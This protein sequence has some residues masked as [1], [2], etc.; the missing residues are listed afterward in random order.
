VV[1]ENGVISEQGRYD[2]LSRTEG[3]RFRKLMAAQLLLEQE[4][5]QQ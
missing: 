4:A 1:L 2:V 3:S 5:N